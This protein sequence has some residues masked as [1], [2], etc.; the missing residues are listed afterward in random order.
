MPK[1]VVVVIGVGGMGREIARRQGSGARLV[2]ADFD[3]ESLASVAEEL[4][5]DGYDITPLRVDVAERASVAEL[6]ATAAGLGPVTQVAHTAGLSPVQAPAAAVLAVDLLGVALVL[7]EFG[8]VV[9]E[10]GAGVVI[11]SMAGHLAPLPPEVEAALRST[12]TDEL[13]DLP[14][15]RPD[16]L[17]DPGAAY[18]FAK[19]GNHLRVQAASLVWGARGARVNT[20]S[21][22]VI[23]TAMGRAELS[24]ESGAR[25]RAMVESS[26]TG[27][28]GTPN[29]ITEAAAF[30]LSPA[31]S[32]VT[33][34]DL[35]V[36][37][38]AVAAARSAAGRGDSAS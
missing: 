10:G 33:G 6:A 34:T 13:L 15:L 20:I 18:A 24:G 16:A 31:A 4:T 7:E 30:L 25:M 22:G 32:F 19:R 21:P 28:T 1:P 26:G 17:A 38:G 5:A 8:A 12:P 3:G 36:D 37:G 14:F 11:A 29:D 2:L 23:S 9:A 27:R 35:L